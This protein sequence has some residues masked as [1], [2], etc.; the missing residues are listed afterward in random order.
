[1]KKLNSLQLSSSSGNITEGI[2]ITYSN[3]PI[4]FWNYGGLITIKRSTG[5]T[6]LPQKTTEWIP[7]SKIVFGNSNNNFLLFYLDESSSLMCIERNFY[8]GEIYN[9]VQVATSVDNF[10]ATPDSPSIKVAFSRSD[11]VYVVGRNDDSRVWGTPSLVATGSGTV[12]AVSIDYKTGRTV[13]A[14]STDSSVAVYQDPEDIPF[15]SPTISGT[16]SDVK[17]RM[18]DS[19]NFHVIYNVENGGSRSIEHS[20]REDTSFWTSQI[21]DDTDDNYNINLYAGTTVCVVWVEGGYVRYREQSGHTW[22]GLEDSAYVAACDSNSTPQVIY[23]EGYSRVVYKSAGIVYYAG[24]VPASQEINAYFNCSVWN[25]TKTIDNSNTS[26]SS[27]L[28]KNRISQRVIFNQKTLSIGSVSCYLKKHQISSGTFTAVMEVYYSDINGSP[29]STPIASSSLLSSEIPNEGW[30]N[31]QFDISGMLVPIDGYCFV[32]HQ[33]GGDEDNYVAWLGYVDGTTNSK[34]SNDGSTWVLSGLSTRS[35]RISGNF[36]AYERIINDDPS[37]ITHQLVTPPATLSEGSINGYNM[38]ASGVFNNTYLVN[39]KEPSY[40]QYPERT[41]YLIGDSLKGEKK[42]CV[43]ISDSGSFKAGDQIY[44]NNDLN[45]LQY[46]Y[47][48]EVGED[49]C[50]TLSS[51]LIYDYTLDNGG[52]IILPSTDPVNQTERIYGY[53]SAGTDWRIEIKDKNV[54][55]SFVVDGS[56]SMGWND[57]FGFR[58]SIINSIISRFK[59]VSGASVLF[60][61]VKFGG[62]LV[63]SINMQFEKKTKSVSVNIDGY[64]DVYGYDPDGNPITDPTPATHLATGVVAYGFKDLHAGATY[65][66][67]G[68]DLGWKKYTFNNTVDP[69][70][71]TLWTS[72][73]PTFSMDTNGPS[74]NKSLNVSVTDDTKNYIRYYASYYNGSKRTRLDG[75]LAIDDTTI[76]VT[77]STGFSDNGRMNIL[78]QTNIN[79]FLF[80]SYVD[81]LIGQITFEPK[82]H[83]NMSTDSTIVETVNSQFVQQGWQNTT[84]FDLYVV[85]SSNSGD[86]TFFIQTYDGA[87]IEYQITP[88]TGWQEMSLYFLDEFAKLEINAVN[89]EGQNFPD[90]TMVEFYVNKQPVNTNQS[91]QE[92]Q[93]TYAILSDAL[94][95]ATVLYVSSDTLA[96]F[97]RNDSIEL[98]DD[99]KSY[100]GTGT[101]EVYFGTVV[102]VN[103][104]NNFLVV[105]PELKGNFL[106]SKNARLVVPATTRDT[107]KLSLKNQLDIVAN[108]VNVTPIL[109]GR[110]LPES[111]FGY[112]DKP[113]VEPTDA[114]DQH[115]SDPTRVTRNS[116]EVLT[117]DGQS[118]VRLLPITEDSFITQETKKANAASLFSESAR[119]QVI[120]SGG[121]LIPQQT[122]TPQVTSS[123]S[124]SEKVYSELPKD[125][126]MDNP[127]Y[128]YNGY[129]STTMQSK[130]A[131]LS[132]T[133]IGSKTYLAKKYSIYPVITFFK[134]NG[135]TLAE[136]ALPSSNLYFA[137][138]VRIATTTDDRVKFTCPPVDPEGGSYDMFCCGNYALNENA[139]TITYHVDYK[140]FALSNGKLTVYIYDARRNKNTSYVTDQDLGD[141]SGCGDE[142]SINGGIMEYSAINEDGV[143]EYALSVQNNLLADSY[144]KPF[145]QSSVF[146]IPVSNGIATLTLPLIDRIAQFE[147]HAIFDITPTSKAVH[148]QS[149]YYKSPLVIKYTGPSQMSNDGSSS[150]NLSAFLTW[151]ELFPV[152][153]GTIVNFS[154]SD[155]SLNP[156]VSETVS[157][158]AQGVI[159]SPI[160]QKETTVTSNS[161]PS[162]I[163][164][165]LKERNRVKS[166]TVSVSATYRGFYVSTSATLTV[167]NEENETTNGDFFFVARSSNSQF[168][169][170]GVDYTMVVADMQESMNR[171]FPFI[172]TIA[173][174]LSQ[175]NMVVVFSAS[176]LYVEGKTARWSCQYDVTLP[177]GSICRSTPPEGIFALPEDLGIYA[178]NRMY[179]NKYIGRPTPQPQSD[180]DRPPPCNAPGCVEINVFTRS[181]TYAAFGYGIDS[182]TVSFAA[183]EANEDI[184]K[185]R[186]G[187]K[188]PLGIDLSFEPV[189]RSEYQN[190]AWRNPPI[191]SHPSTHTLDTSSYPIRRDGKS[192]QHIVAEVTWRDRFIFGTESNPFPTVYFA[193][194][195]LDVNKAGS[196]S[197]N[198][199]E[200]DNYLLDIKEAVVSIAR[201]T[202]DEDHF[203][204]C[205]V[206]ESGI[207]STTATISCIKGVV[208]SD[209]THEIDMSTSDYI[210]YISFIKETTDSYGSTTQVTVNHKHTPRSVAVISGGPVSDLVLKLTV[211]GE[212]TYDNGKIKNDGTRVQRTLDNYAFSIPEEEATE[213]VGGGGVYARKYVL[214][215]VTPEE[216]IGNTIIPAIYTSADKSHSGSTI[217]FKAYLLDENLNK[218]PVPDGTRIFTSYKFFEPP[219]KTGQ[220]NKGDILVIEQGKVKDYAVL[221]INA[222]ISGLPVEVSA[223][224]QVKIESLLSWYPIVENSVFNSATDD[225]IYLQRAIATLSEIGGS[226][227]NDALITAANRIIKLGQQY[228]SWVKVIVLISD[229]SENMSENSHAQA[230]DAIDTINGDDIT[231][232][233]SVKL[234][235]TENFDCINMQKYSQNTGGEY[236][237]LSQVVGTV[238]ETSEEIV[239]RI[240]GSRSFRALSGTYTNVIDLSQMKDFIAIKFGVLM[241]SGTEMSFRVRFSQDG[242][243]YGEWN[244]LPSKSYSGVDSVEWF[245]VDLSSLD[246]MARYMQYEANL[247][248]DPLTFQSPQ[249][250]GIAYDYYEPG[251]YV[252]FF[253][254]ISIEKPDHYVG[255]IIFIQEGTVPATSSIRYGLTHDTSTDFDSYY[256]SVGQPLFKDGISGFVLSRFNEKTTTYDYKTY[257]AVNG[258]WNDSYTASVY[259]I[260]SDS[261]QGELVPQSSYTADG[262]T[263]IIVFNVA[264]PM[265]DEFTLV[266][267]LKPYFRVAVDMKNYGPDTIVLDNLS[268]TYNLVDRN[269]LSFQNDHRDVTSLVE[270]N[271]ESFNITSSG[272]LNED[273]T[274]S[275]AKLGQ[276]T[277]TIID[278]SL[279]EITYTA[280]LHNGTS[281]YLVDMEKNLT[282]IKRYD[283]TGGTNFIPVSS[284]FDGD[285]WYFVETTPRG[286]SIHKY[287]KEFKFVNTSPYS[288][289]FLESST[290]F[291]NIRRYNSYWYLTENDRIHV[292][293]R[294]F[295]FDHSVLLP[296]N[297]SGAFVVSDANY[298]LLSQ[299]KDFLWNVDTNGQVKGGYNLGTSEIINN[300]SLLDSTFYVIK[301]KYF[302]SMVAE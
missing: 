179:S 292:L 53:N 84:S 275:N 191:G 162:E 291:L 186:I 173:P 158:V 102:E 5:E 124:V 190:V 249:L 237:K 199:V 132:S 83:Y 223:K 57:P 148:K 109:T 134:E 79:N 95:G 16:S 197:D 278:L 56:G 105:S 225:G 111:M 299:T 261:P 188:E 152:D 209:H 6:W 140:D 180:S 256:S 233:F 231:N 120:D 107:N 283:L 171:G 39:V 302:A 29:Y 296:F 286:I 201:T 72:S 3:V 40:Y 243:T 73:E 202:I 211:K 268:F 155:G 100:S 33:E 146:E 269:K 15:P 263:G 46:N 28:V 204:E 262:K 279:F 149:V 245:V 165:Y 265:S 219:I 161:T 194:G 216:K 157:G 235:D 226:Q 17:I 114:Y 7:Y 250:A 10:D 69:N 44:L 128:V 170:D 65:V 181:K 76:L 203:H 35:L 272:T 277:D 58:E 260:N 51:E 97:S 187:L 246:G 130:S 230:T 183:D 195:D 27:S 96:E 92:T 150:Y 236:F 49:G 121:V 99:D 185:P 118:A 238:E 129:A 66:V 143:D 9:P 71:H 98:T 80:I 142:E 295:V 74:G 244:E 68:I 106:I 213:D 182:Y 55:I 214:E 271:Y 21:V 19:D 63:D 126:V 62:L 258:G 20:A 206:D 78:D 198:F 22:V 229:G 200:N 138:P 36:N 110:K 210:T 37:K 254:P 284:N 30:K 234:S 45:Q 290:M 34:V 294:S 144:L 227:V 145:G 38:L 122:D 212:V 222:K 101:N 24:M 184:P 153:D 119:Q 253:Q 207:G 103:S 208:V 64:T 205:Y 215:I 242:I 31:F 221:E 175:N 67:Y 52:Y 70:W 112:L 93:E 75:A 266:I 241:R 77:D 125:Y 14:Y 251:R 293:N 32:M 13:V 176:G 108:L 113:Q 50:L 91:T 41:F 81:D 139:V 285:Y 174:D 137:C 8:T 87:T 247:Q 281:P 163:N 123:S 273:N 164:E 12:N 232:V 133:T 298:W 154:A 276:D 248:G 85:D 239:N 289:D 60:D 23:Y 288:L 88:M 217:I 252:M 257:S 42:V 117:T 224:K 280:T 218:I 94:I 189:D 287:T 156:S 168:F 167:Q 127:V 151:M 166:S 220:E 192:K 147:I 159:F 89:S 172:D 116:I 4:V 301:D 274:V 177:D 2:S 59:S 196:Y 136:M 61:F 82:S 270:T 169:A 259:R 86:I 11:K 104:A 131:S 54:I 255:E 267:S 141:V 282:I 1:M 193:S 300:L 297:I 115:N 18:V 135:Q 160:I 25:S 48:T 264:Q 43:S 47:V 178:W 228:D 26:I 240:L 90:G